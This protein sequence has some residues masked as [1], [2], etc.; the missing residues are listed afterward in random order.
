AETLGA[1]LARLGWLPAEV[2]ASALVLGRDLLAG[3]LDGPSRI[4]AAAVVETG[5][6]AY[7]HLE[8]IWPLAEVA[9]VPPEDLWPLRMLGSLM[10]VLARLEVEEDWPALIATAA[11]DGL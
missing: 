9:S 5:E 4:D 6:R 3:H 2:G 1:S 7:A 8:A 10:L 11:R